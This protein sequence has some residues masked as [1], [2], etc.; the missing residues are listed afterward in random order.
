MQI[1]R[2]ATWVAIA[3]LLSMFVAINW[4]PVRINFWPNEQDYQGFLHFNWPVG[5]VA[6]LF[7]L[8]GLLPMWLLSKAGKWRL[9]RRINVLE[10]TVKAVAPSP[11]QTPPASPV[12]TPTQPEAESPAA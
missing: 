9:N 10:N 3:I 2:T 7:F 4:T 12:A 11:A 8:L 5:L 1:I 6:I